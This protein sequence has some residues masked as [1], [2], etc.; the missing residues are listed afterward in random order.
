VVGADL[1]PDRRYRLLQRVA[2]IKSRLYKE[3]EV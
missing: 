1:R 3:P 2:E